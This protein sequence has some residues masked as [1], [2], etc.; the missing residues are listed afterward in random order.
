LAA[1]IAYK[2]TVASCAVSHAC[3][4]ASRVCPCRQALRRRG[5]PERLCVVP[6]LSLQLLSVLC[7]VHVAETGD[8]LY[9][10]KCA[11]GV[12]RRAAL[13]RVCGWHRR[14]GPHTLPQGPGKSLASVRACAG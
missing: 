13:R 12:L 9:G 4:A 1:V 7:D 11:L 14:R 6:P 2:S 5:F 10:A 8:S 3:A